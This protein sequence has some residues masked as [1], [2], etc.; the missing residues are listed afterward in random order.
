MG[1]D[2]AIKQV[3]P[4]GK[5]GPDLDHDHDPG[6]LHAAQ[7]GKEAAKPTVDA[8][9]SEAMNDALLV[10]AQG[11]HG[12]F[13]KSEALL[14]AGGFQV[15]IYNQNIDEEKGALDVVEKKYDAEL[16]KANSSEKTIDRLADQI[17]SHRSN[18][19]N[20]RTAKKDFVD[21][22]RDRT[23]EPLLKDKVLALQNVAAEARYFGWSA[24]QHAKVSTGANFLRTM[25]KQVH[26]LGKGL[27]LDSSPSLQALDQALEEIV[28]AMKLTVSDADPKELD[29]IDPQVLLQKSV[30]DNLVAAEAQARNAYAAVHAWAGR[31]KGADFAHVQGS[32]QAVAFHIS[33]AVDLLGQLKP[34]DRHQF[35]PL[36]HGLVKQV[37]AVHHIGQIQAN[38]HAPAGSASMEIDAFPH[39]LDELRKAIGA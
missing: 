2:R 13:V 21:G 5:H 8:L 23:F 17:E 38:G 35:K 11:L 25:L 15:S 16:N 18:L 10:V 4:G 3:T 33:D 19:G 12:A 34:A 9:S 26:E 31:K 30:R 32:V 1:L 6:V 22:I 29:K 37:E 20:T 39:A 28:G 7:V 27:D 36:L 14:K 24:D